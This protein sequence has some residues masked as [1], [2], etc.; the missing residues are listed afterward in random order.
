MAKEKLTP[1]EEEI[2]KTLADTG[3]SN[4]KIAN[5][6]HINYNTVRVHLQNAFPKMDVHCRHEAI[7]KYRNEKA[8]TLNYENS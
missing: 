6:L 4:K 2:I 8:N 7:V 5:F 3:W 1:R